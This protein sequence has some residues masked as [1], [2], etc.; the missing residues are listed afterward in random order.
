MDAVF[1]LYELSTEW[2]RKNCISI[3]EAGT[4]CYSRKKEG[5]M[6]PSGIG[7]RVVRLSRA[8]PGKVTFDL[9]LKAKWVFNRQK[10]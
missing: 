9:E 1:S 2:R 10:I 4:K 8:S 3:V 6:T 5:A 7:R